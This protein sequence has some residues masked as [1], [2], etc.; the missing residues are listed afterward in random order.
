M[1]LVKVI[2]E[3]KTLSEIKEHEQELWKSGLQQVSFQ[4]ERD[5]CGDVVYRVEY[6]LRGLL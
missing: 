5:W 4:T 6:L 3:Y 1:R 2:Y